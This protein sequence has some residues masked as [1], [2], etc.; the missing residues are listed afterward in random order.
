MVDIF[1]NSQGRFS[2]D[3]L[4]RAVR[5][6]DQCIG[7]ATV[8]RALRLLARRGLQRDPV[9]TARSFARQVE[10]TAPGPAATVFAR[11]TE[12]YLHQRFSG[13]PADDMSRDLEQLR[14]SLR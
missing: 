7:A 10:R 6:R 4:F 9:T 12:A 2:A 11:I 1:F 13:I 8:Y 14:V 5:A 3:E